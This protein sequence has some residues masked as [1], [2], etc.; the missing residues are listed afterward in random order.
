MNNNLW[1]IKNLKCHMDVLQN[2]MEDLIQSNY[3][4]L[5]D[6]FEVEELKTKADVMKHGCGYL[7]QRIKL[8]QSV[9]LLQTYK[10]EMDDLIAELDSEINKLKEVE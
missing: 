4:L 10:K 2:K 8:N 6:Y 3:W 5:E 1:E 7:E 9:T